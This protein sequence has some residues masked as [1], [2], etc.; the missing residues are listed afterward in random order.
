MFRVQKRNSARTAVADNPNIASKSAHAA[1]T[2]KTR[3][4]AAALA[5][6]FVTTLTFAQTWPTKPVRVVVPA[7]AG[8]SL[9]F[10]ARVLGEKLGA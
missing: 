5:A 9:D 3:H 1:L 10:V 8:S 4:I 2:M 7:P 6:T